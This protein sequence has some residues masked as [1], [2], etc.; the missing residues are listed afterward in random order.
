MIQNAQHLA[1]REMTP[2]SDNLI[3]VPSTDILHDEVN[4]IVA[5]IMV[6]NR[7]DIRM[8]DI[9]GDYGFR[10]KALTDSGFAREIVVQ[11]FHDDSAVKPL[12]HAAVDAGHSAK[13]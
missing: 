12:I 11:Y 7:N 2:L 10:L 1:G 4:E 9:R 8:R 3:E 6:A 13:S 5:D